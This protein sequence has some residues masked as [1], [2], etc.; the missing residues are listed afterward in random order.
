LKKIK[1]SKN[2]ALKVFKGNN[3]LYFSDFEDSIKSCTP[4]EWVLVENSKKSQHFVAYINPLVANN[5]P[6]GY[7]MMEYTGKEFEAEALLKSLIH[8]AIYKRQ[9]FKGYE[10][11]SRVI[12][13]EADNLPGL[14]ADAYKN[15]VVVQ[16]NT[17][18]LDRYRDLIREILIEKFDNKKIIFLDNERYREREGLPAHPAEPIEE[19][20]LIEENGLEL[21]V[22]SGS[23]QKVG[24]YYDHRENRLKAQ[25]I[26][27]R[28]NRKFTKGLDL[29][30][31]V[32][33]WGLN[34]LKADCENV[35]FVDQGNFEESISR[36]LEMNGYSCRGSFVRADVFKYLK[37]CT[38]TFD[39]ICS[40]PPAFCKSKKEEKR[41][42][43]GYTKLHRAVFKLLAKDSLFFACSCTHYIDHESFQKNIKDA[44]K[45]SGREIHLLEVGMQ[46][47]DHPVK[48]LHDKNSYLKYFVYL[49]E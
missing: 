12:F 31:Y 6:C 49:V 17:A 11:C 38:E 32:G 33:S 19:D 16:I 30:S 35:T 45:L 46:G 27:N 37:E 43:E 10:V 40:D 1:L 14:I 8:K 13:G 36:N 42:Y 3:E 28:M 44:A 4:G 41:A 22:C 29:F 39:V 26:M 2:G 34:M 5:S 24:Y 7:V 23:I 21:T 9:I 25:S 47:F 18:G 20:L 15:Y 48:S